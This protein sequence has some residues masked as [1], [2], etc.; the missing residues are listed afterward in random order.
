MFLIEY[1]K[2]QYI[3]A[4]RINHISLGSDKVIFTIC[5]EPVTIFPVDKAIECQF[6]NQIQAL[7]QSLTNPS[8][9][10]R[11]LSNPTPNTKVSK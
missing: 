1:R 3:D 5:G 10:H 4:E 8:A 2:D 11:H 6:L 7:N 9:R